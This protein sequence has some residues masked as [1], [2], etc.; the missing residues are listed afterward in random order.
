MKVQRQRI[1]RKVVGQPTLVSAAPK[2]SLMYNNCY[3]PKDKAKRVETQKERKFDNV[4][5]QIQAETQKLD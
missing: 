4:W 1:A 3:I 2:N 5:K